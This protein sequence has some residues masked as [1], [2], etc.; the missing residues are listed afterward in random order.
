MLFDIGTVVLGLIILIGAG[1]LLVRGAV[2]LALRL[3][4][5][6][7]VVSLTIVALGTSAPELLIAVDSVLKDAPDLA[8]GNVVGSNIANVLLVLGVPALIA[9]LAPPGAESHRTYVFMLAASGLLIA[10]SYFGPIDLTVGIVFI[11][12]F[13]L[14]LYDT[15]QMAKSTRVDSSEVDET[16]GKTSGYLIAAF[17]IAGLIGLPLGADLLV[18][19]AVNLA[20][21]L[22]ISEAIIGLTIVAIGTSLPELATSIMAAIR[23]E[24]GVVIGGI[25]GSNLFNILAILGTA[26]F[27]GQLPVPPGFLLV[28]YWV[29]LGASLAII[30]TVF[31]GFRLSRRWG[32]L[33]LGAYGIYIASLVA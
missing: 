5:T 9:P 14:F 13:F 24:A 19:G 25:V 18:E 27:F 10:M 15:F 3:G 4:I 22:G 20:A 30:P 2:A 33:F 26:S 31:L 28:D 29:M 23:R 16:A 11:T 12:F 8:L 7:I 1:D 21:D 6:P 32:V 17:L